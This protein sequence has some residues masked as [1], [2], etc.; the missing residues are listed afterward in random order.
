MSLWYSV[1]Y[2]VRLHFSIDRRLLR[3]TTEYMLDERFAATLFYGK[4]RQVRAIP[5]ILGNREETLF[6]NVT[7]FSD[8][9]KPLTTEKCTLSQSPCR[10]S[11]TREPGNVFNNDLRLH[12]HSGPLSRIK[13]PAGS[14]KNLLRFV[15][16]WQKGL[17]SDDSAVFLLISVTFPSN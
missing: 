11:R 15:E 8:G 17:L 4:L 14:E 3:R 1:L 16:I 7:G 6:L 13:S 12:A 2:M 10:H 5:A 9:L